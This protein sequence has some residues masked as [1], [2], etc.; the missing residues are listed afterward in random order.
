MNRIL[1]HIRQRNAGFTLLEVVVVMVILGLVLLLLAQILVTTEKS[2]KMNRQVEDAGQNARVAMEF[3]TKNLR[4]AGS[5]VDR[6]AGQQSFVLAEP[7]QVIFNADI[8]PG[9]FD[10]TAVNPPEAIDIGVTPAQIP[11]A[12]TPLYA[13]SRTFRTGAESIWITLDS[14]QDG[15]VNS[16]DQ[17]DD[18]EEANLKNTTLYALHRSIYGFQSDSTNGGAAAVTALIRGPVAYS[19]GTNPPPLFSYWLDTD[20]NPNTP[21][22]LHGDG[23]GDKQLSNSE[24]A[25]LGPVP[26]A[27]LHMIRRIEVNVV[28]GGQQIDG[29]VDFNGGFREVSLSSQINV[30]ND[31]PGSARLIGKVFTDIDSDGVID[32]GETG[33]PKVQLRLNTGATFSSNGQGE[34]L[35]VVQPGN[36]T[37]QEFDPPGYSSSTGNIVGVNVSPGEL[38]VTNFGDYPSAGFG[39]ITGRVWND[40]NADGVKQGPETLLVDVKVSLNTG[41]NMLTDAN[42]EYLFTVPVSSYTVSATVPAGF[43]PTT[44]PSEAVTLNTAGQTKKVDFG[45]TRQTNVGTIEGYVFLDVNSNQVMDL[46]ENGLAD[47]TIQTS[48]GDSAV[49]DNS[50]FYRMN[51]TPGVYDVEEIEP[52]GYTSTTPNVYSNVTV[53]IDSTIVLNYGDILSTSLD[54]DEISLNSSDPVLSITST[55]LQEDTRGDPDL[56]VGSTFNSGISNILVYWNDR[57]NAS[58]PPSA[59]FPMTP[60]FGRNAPHDV[61]T[62]DSGNLNGD[63][64]DDVTSGLNYDVGTNVDTWFTLKGG[65]KGL[66]PTSPQQSYATL[67]ITRAMKIVARD[68]NA[69]GDIDLVV[70]KDITSASFLGEVEIFLGNGSGSYTSTTTL[71]SFGGFPLHSVRDMAVAD[72]DNNGHPDIVMGLNIG[73]TQGMIAAYMN[74]G[75]NS[76]TEGVWAYTAGRVN[77]VAAIDMVE[78]NLGTVDILAASQT[79]STSGSVELWHGTLSGGVYSIPTSL[80]SDVYTPPGAPTALVVGTFDP[81]IFPDVVVGTRDSGAYSGHVYG[82]KAFGFLPSSSSPINLTTIGEVVTAHV[83]D[84]NLDFQKDF[85]IGTRTGATSGNV[86]IF[87]NL[88]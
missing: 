76:Y 50:G 38:K 3:I 72:L 66:L 44:P 2:R 20:G 77:A 63:P 43:K 12:G 67:G 6:A 87:F 80:P 22:I 84:F 49:T 68:M 7:Y 85:A 56:V 21:E 47:V 61:L 18:A 52:T 13:P 1:S 74:Q 26:L 33:I 8:E 24:I 64:I 9:I 15:V 71:N 88:N 40:D 23:D 79:S 16:S 54:F 73:T 53:Y 25:A 37:I 10:P 29:S 34:Y 30:R 65:S 62:L 17:G 83:D 45:F 5:S 48:A 78:N 39:E 46:G 32:A 41:E 86:V 57:K 70:G 81:D 31:Q 75:S 55:D 69:D 35:F 14:N 60:T 27:Q 11:A 82:L 51:V 58:T 42:G 4:M 36:Y 28:G 59:I 19:D